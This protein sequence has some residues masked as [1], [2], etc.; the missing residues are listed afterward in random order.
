MKR[1]LYLALCCLAAAAT[2]ACFGYERRSTVTQPTGASG[3]AGL[4]GSWTS[5]NVVPSPSTC[6]D[7]KWNVTE[8][9]TNS[10]RG[11]FSATCANSLRLSGTAE[12]TLSG[13]VIAWKAQGTATAPDLPSCAVSLEGTAEIATDSVRV[14][15]TGDTCAGR[16]SGTEI[17]RRQ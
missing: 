1:P 5:A 2:T 4:L 15:Y 9:T 16:V 12:G 11:S 7:F 6:T 10:A 13:S 8:Q 14:P 17:L 3:V